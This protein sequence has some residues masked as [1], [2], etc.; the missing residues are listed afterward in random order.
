MRLPLNRL[1][2]VVSLNGAKQFVH[3]ELP[4]AIGSP[5]VKTVPQFVW[6]KQPRNE[7][8][9]RQAKA[10]RCVQMA[11]TGGE[12]PDLTE[13]FVACVDCGARATDWEHRDYSAPLAV[14]PVCR[15]CNCLRGAAA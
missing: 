1:S 3:S 13:T 10:H 5:I 8:A 15:S 2:E 9:Y 14:E 6:E 11:V 12:L 4:H 7:R